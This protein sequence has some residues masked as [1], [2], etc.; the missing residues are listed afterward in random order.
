MYRHSHVRDQIQASLFERKRVSQKVPAKCLYLQ[1]RLASPLNVLNLP[2]AVVTQKIK[3]PLC[4]SKHH[5]MK[6]LCLTK[7]HTVK[8]YSGVEA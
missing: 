2:A 5:V 1:S 8:M 3:Y 4:I 6:T 7:H